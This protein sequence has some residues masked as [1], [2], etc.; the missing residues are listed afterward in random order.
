VGGIVF[1]GV[2]ENLDDTGALVVRTAAGL[3]RVTAGEVTWL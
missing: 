3:A 2:A 1:D